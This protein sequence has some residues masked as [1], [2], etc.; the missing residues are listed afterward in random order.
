MVL[1]IDYTRDDGCWR[2]IPDQRLQAASSFCTPTP[3]ISKA[4]T[5]QTENEHRLATIR[6]PDRPAVDLELIVDAAA[7]YS[8]AGIRRRNEYGRD[9][10]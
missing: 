6:Q 7:T 8:M 10:M 4:K 1:Q 3:K 2:A 9:M 5:E